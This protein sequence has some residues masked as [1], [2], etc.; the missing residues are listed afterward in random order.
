MLKRC[1]SWPFTAQLK[2]PSSSDFLLSA[3]GFTGSAFTGWGLFRGLNCGLGF[4]L[5]VS[6]V[7]LDGADLAGLVGVEAMTGD[8]SLGIGFSLLGL[9]FLL[10]ILSSLSVSSA[11][12]RC[13]DF[14]GLGSLL[15][16]KRLNES[17]TRMKENCQR[18]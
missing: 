8:A 15:S 17:V 13:L 2:V 9:G 16:G 12:S 11:V 14:A 18:R 6:L 10:S 4:S 7:L 5:A 1:R 3:L